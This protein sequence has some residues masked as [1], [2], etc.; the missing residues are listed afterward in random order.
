MTYLK[1]RMTKGGK[2]G[3]LSPDRIPRVIPSRLKGGYNLEGSRIGMAEG[4]GARGA[5]GRRGMVAE[6]IGCP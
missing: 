5:E 4:R 1:M 3:I 2:C 6:M